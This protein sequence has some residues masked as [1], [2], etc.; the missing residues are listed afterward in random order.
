MIKN[1]FTNVGAHGMPF[2]PNVFIIGAQKSGTSALHSYLSVADEIFSTKI[3]ECCTLRSFDWYASHSARARKKPFIDKKDYHDKIMD[4][5][6]NERYIV[7]ASTYYTLNDI[8]KD[9]SIPEVMS[10]FSPDCKIIYILRNPVERLISA[11]VQAVKAGGFLGSLADFYCSSGGN[12]AVLTSCYYY[13]LCQYLDLFARENILI[14]DFNDLISCP[15]KTLKEVYNFLDISED[16][17]KFKEDYPI[18]HPTLKLINVNKKDLLFPSDIFSDIW[19]KIS[20]DVQELKG[21]GI[22]FDWDI[23]PDRWSTSAP[24]KSFD[25]FPYIGHLY[26]RRNPNYDVLLDFMRVGKDRLSV[27]TAFEEH[28]FALEAKTGSVE[29]VIAE[30]RKLLSHCDTNP[31]CYYHF[32]KL[33]KRNDNLDGAGEAMQ[34]A[35]ALD[36]ALPWPHIELSR[37]YSLLGDTEGAIQKVRDA[38][39]AKDDVPDFYFRLGQLLNKQGDFEG[40]K[41]AM[42]KVVA[43]DSSLSGSYIELSLIYIRLGDIEQAIQNARDA[44]IVEDD[45]PDYYFHLG[46]LLNKKGDLEGARDAMKKAIALDPSHPDFHIQLSHIYV[47]LGDT[48]RALQKARDAIAAKKGNSGSYSNLENLL[49]KDR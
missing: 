47:Q 4:G 9:D 6:K 14:V 22:E 12:N 27:G 25:V 3:K 15:H 43:L 5:Y 37:I 36:P 10:H 34:K 45:N 42:E 38:I 29:T 16:K 7:E 13:Q 48:E 40:A 20:I 30:S 19:D 24:V 1:V 28:I 32:G 21:L 26:L 41:D 49:K 11:Y 46:H 8:A 35:I 23:T 17:H 18:I 2:V 31:F 39:A 33:L 44:V